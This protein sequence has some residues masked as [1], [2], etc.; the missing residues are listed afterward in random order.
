MKKFIF[1]LLAGVSLTSVVSCTK[2]AFL[3]DDSLTGRLSRVDQKP[4][5]GPDSDNGGEPAGNNVDTMD[6][7]DNPTGAESGQDESRPEENL[8]GG[9]GT[10][11]GTAGNNV[12]SGSNGQ[13]TDGNNPTSGSQT[14]SGG[15]KPKDGEYTVQVGPDLYFHF[16]GWDEGEATDENF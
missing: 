3:P 1:I 9:T 13:Q 14:D 12:G 6:E 5:M 2:D 8:P 16:S 4:E 7:P 15:P 11:D 10:S